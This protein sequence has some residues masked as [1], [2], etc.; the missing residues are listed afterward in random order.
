MKGPKDIAKLRKFGVGLSVLIV[1]I[2]GGFLPWVFNFSWPLWPWICGGIVLA[3][4][5]VI[6]AALM[7]VQTGLVRVAEPIGRVNS[8]IL[9]SIVYYLLVCPMGITMRLLKKDPIQKSFD[10][11]AKTYRRNSDPLTSLKVPF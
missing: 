4:A 7:P 5:F 9:L 6:P 11:A 8:A 3:A 2:F 1:A 10:P